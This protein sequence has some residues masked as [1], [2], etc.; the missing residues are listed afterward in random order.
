MVVAAT[1]ALRVA[2]AK[3]VRSIVTFLQEFWVGVVAVVTIT[4][5]ETCTVRLAKAMA[6]IF[7]AFAVSTATACRRPTPTI[8]VIQQIAFIPTETPE[9]ALKVATAYV[10][11]VVEAR[12][13][14]VDQIA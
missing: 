9:S 7:V 12:Y 5:R 2:V 1:F 13:I 10:H 14:Q 6:A 11:D 8:G 3:V 4:V